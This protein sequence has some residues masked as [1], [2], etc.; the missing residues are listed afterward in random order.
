MQVVLDKISYIHNKVSYKP[1]PPEMKLYPKLHWR[2]MAA[3]MDV[4]IVILVVMPFIHQPP[5]D[6][7][8]IELQKRLESQ[9]IPPQEAMNQFLD[10]FLN[11]GGLA[12]VVSSGITQFIL[13]GFIVLLFWFYKSATPGKMLMGMEIVDAKTF[14]KPTRKQ[15]FIRYLSYALSLIPFTIGLLMVLFTKRRQGLH[16]KLSGTVVVF[17]RRIPKPEDMKASNAN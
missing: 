16:D 5:P 4:F 14:A 1:D 8:I 12:H 3:M 17:K 7:E 13:F 2:I 10:Y 9:S 15:F 11:K 6:N